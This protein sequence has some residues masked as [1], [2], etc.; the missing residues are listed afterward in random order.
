[1]HAHSHPPSVR[2]SG[3]RNAYA[4]HA[5]GATGYYAESGATYSNPHDRGVHEMLQSA[6]RAWPHLFF[7]DIPAS[8][9]EQEEEEEEEGTGGEGRIL[10]LSCG[11]GEVTAALVAAGVNLDRIDAC[12]PYTVRQPTAPKNP[13]PHEPCQS[14]FDDTPFKRTCDVFL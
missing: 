8:S 1:M 6:V 12:D 4:A 2:V 10:D 3:V 9:E 7:A 5:Q 11:S 13:R 14:T